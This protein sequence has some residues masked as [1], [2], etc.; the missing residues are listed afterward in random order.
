VS[1]QPRRPVLL[2]G[3]QRELVDAARRQSGA[4]HRRGLRLRT[5]A[6][7]VTAVV[8]LTPPSSA[9]LSASASPTSVFSQTVASNV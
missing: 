2:G 3:V 1:K 6:V 9:A 8:L 5:A 4:E 7:A